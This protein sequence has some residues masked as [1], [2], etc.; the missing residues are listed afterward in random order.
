MCRHHSQIRRLEQAEDMI[1]DAIGLAFDVAPD[2]I[3]VDGPIPIVNPHLDELLQDT[4]ASRV[5]LAELRTKVDTLTRRV[6]P[7]NWLMRASP[8]GTLRR[9]WTFLSNTPPSLRSRLRRTAD[10]WNHRKLLSCKGFL[11]TR[12]TEPLRATWVS[13]EMFEQVFSPLDLA[14]PSQG[15]R[16]PLISST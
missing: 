2:V 13:G 4:K 14:E 15:R 3:G 16:A 6:A 7:T 5:Q 10:G 12:G 11:E 8:F 1:R 9:H